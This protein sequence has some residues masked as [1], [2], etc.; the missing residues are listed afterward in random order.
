MITSRDDNTYIYDVGDKDKLRLQI[1]N[2]VYNPLSKQALL[3]IGI[4][5][6]KCVIDIACGQGEMTCW[7]AQQVSPDSTVIGVDISDEQLVLAKQLAQKMELKNVRFIKKSVLDKDF[8]NVM[9]ELPCKP[10]LIYSRWL[11]IHLE[12]E[13]VSI[14]MRALYDLL[15]P[16]GIMAHEEVTLKESFLDPATESFKQ[17][18]ALFTGLAEKLNINFDLGSDLQKLFA[19]I[20]YKHS[21]FKLFKPKYTREQLYFFQLDLESAIPILGKCNLAQKADI[22]KLNAAIAEEVD[23]GADM[24]MTNYFVYGNK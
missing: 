12:K 9:A 16:E 3:D 11:L 1:L 6:K 7:M 8:N 4:Q 14:A 21:K 18:V 22:T 19:E 13:K 15:G 2:D 23:N 10:D 5:S 20:G 17:Y 24:T